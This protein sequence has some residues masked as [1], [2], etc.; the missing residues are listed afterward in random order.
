MSNKKGH[1]SWGK[2]HRFYK[3]GTGFE[4]NRQLFD[5]L[6]WR[7][8]GTHDACVD[9][10]KKAKL[11]RQKL[12]LFIQTYDRVQFMLYIEFKSNQSSGLS[13]PSL[14]LG[15]RHRDDHGDGFM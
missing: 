1:F 12:A 9:R 11:K 13:V 6:N 3:G 8:S 10:V 2:V 5:F 15:L 7:K 4:K 14:R